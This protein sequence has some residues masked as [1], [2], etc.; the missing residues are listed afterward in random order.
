MF[1]LFSL[2]VLGT[3]LFAY[4]ALSPSRQSVVIPVDRTR[5][6][7]WLPQSRCDEKLQRFS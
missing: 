3:L 2:S 6:G 1:A 5:D 7:P 4:P